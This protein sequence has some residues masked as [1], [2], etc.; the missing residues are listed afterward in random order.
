MQQLTASKTAAFNMASIIRKGMGALALGILFTACKKDDKDLPDPNPNP[1]PQNESYYAAKTNMALQYQSVEGGATEQYTLTVTGQKDSA[2]GKVYNYRNAF[3]DGTAIN[4]FVY[5]KGNSFTLVSTVPA[6]L[7]S[8]IDEMKDDPTVSDFELS[9]LPLQQKLPAN[10]QVNQALE[11]SDPM[12]MGLNIHD[13]EES[14]TM[15]MDMYFGFSDGKVVGFEEV[16]TP[17]GTFKNCM[18]VQ[19]KATMTLEMPVGGNESETL[20]TQWF[21][22]G[23][24]LVKSEE[25]EGTNT[26]TTTL[27]GVTGK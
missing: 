21:A 8:I 18:K 22:K 6:E 3:A 13:E 19:Y 1:Q 15:R 4:P 16:T 11:F 10:P 9:G 26:S 25:K 20:I 23:I 2:G 24:G 17:A 7:A 5:A 27:I 14:E 12:H